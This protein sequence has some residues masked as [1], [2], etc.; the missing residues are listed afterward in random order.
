MAIRNGAIALP[1]QQQPVPSAAGNIMT[2]FLPETGLKELTE[3]D[4]SSKVRRLRPACIGPSR[5][6]KSFVCT[7]T[8]GLRPRQR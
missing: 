2:L 3:V 1:S 6:H 8:R 4:A 5:A 7:G